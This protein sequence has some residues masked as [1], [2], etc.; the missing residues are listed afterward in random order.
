MFQLYIIKKG[1]NLKIVIWP[2]IKKVYAFIGYFVI[3]Y[4]IIL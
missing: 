3:F 4:Y 1:N 2:K